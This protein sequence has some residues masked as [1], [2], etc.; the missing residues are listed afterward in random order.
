M[1]TAEGRT[2]WDIGA[3]KLNIKMPIPLVSEDNIFGNEDD[4]M[5][6]D[7]VIRAEAILNT[8]NDIGGFF[9]EFNR[10]KALDRVFVVFDDGLGDPD[11]VNAGGG[12]GHIREWI[13]GGSVPDL[14]DG[15]DPMA[16]FVILGNYFSQNIEGSCSRTLKPWALCA[17]LSCW[18]SPR[19]SSPP[20][21]ALPPPLA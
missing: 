13:D 17:T 3:E 9:D 18:P 12:Y 20:S 11:E 4:H 10:L 7:H 8:I 15:T 16:G 1:Y 19:P 6:V 21:W 2:Y 14:E 5:T